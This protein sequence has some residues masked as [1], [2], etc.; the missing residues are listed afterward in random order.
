MPV[1]QSTHLAP[2][3]VGQHG[4]V[5][6]GEG[7]VGLDEVQVFSRL[8]IESHAHGVVGGD[9]RQYKTLLHRQL[10]SDVLQ[11]GLQAPQ[12]LPHFLGPSAQVDVAVEMQLEPKQH[13]VEAAG[14]A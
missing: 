13:S 6:V 9:Q 10:A 5:L 12:A 7:G 1:L 8:D 3:L 14:P 2:P 4:E 11:G